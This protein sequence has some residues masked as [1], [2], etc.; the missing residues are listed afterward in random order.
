MVPSGDGTYE[1]VILVSLRPKGILCTFVNIRCYQD[2]AFTTPSVVNT[3]VNGIDGY[4]TS[5]LLVQHPT[6][7]GFWKIYGRAD[8]QI[9][10]ST[11]EKVSSAGFVIL[12]IILIGNT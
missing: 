1:L 9:M 3:K 7:P 6:K 4:A 12:I 2:S 11:G 10:H 5:D 8:D